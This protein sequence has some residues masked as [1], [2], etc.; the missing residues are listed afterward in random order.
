MKDVQAKILA[1]FETLPAQDRQDLLDELSR[2]VGSSA[3]DDGL[4]A[5]DVAA[6]EEGWAQIKRGEGR[7]VDEVLDRVAARFGFPR[8]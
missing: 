1:L 5:E 3:S 7:P 4:T 2:S 8:A 6:I